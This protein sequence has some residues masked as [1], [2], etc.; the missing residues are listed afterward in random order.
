MELIN[1]EMSWLSFN[2]RVLQEAIDRNVPLIERIRFLGIYSNNM[3]EFFRVRVANI[4]RMVAI[5]KNTVQGY[6]GSAQDLLEEIRSIVIE[7]QKVFEKTY[8]SLVEELKEVSVFQVNEKTLSE[9]GRK[10]VQTFFHHDLKHV[11][12]PII[13]DPTREFP[14]LR[15][16]SIYLA[17]RLTVTTKKKPLF[18]L[19]EIPSN[20]PRFYQ[21]NENGSDYFLLIDD[22]I[23]LNLDSIFS[24]FQAEDLE[25]YTFKFTRDAELNLD[26]DLSVSFIEKI[27]KSLKNRKKG[28]PVRFVYDQRMPTD[29][30]NFLLKSLNLKS[31]SNAIP[32]GRYHNFK[33]FARFPDFGKK[34]L[35]YPQQTPVDN[36]LFYRTHSFIKRVLEQD[37]LLHFPYQRFDHV[38]DLLREA[39]ID[40]KVQSIKINVYRVASDSQIMNALMSA[41]S[42]GKEVVVMLELQARFDEENNLYWAERLKEHGAKVIYGIQG[43][44]V[45]SKLLQIIRVSKTKEQ[46]ISFIGTGNFNE[47]TARIYGDLGLLTADHEINSEVKKVFRLLENNIER[48]I[49]KHILVSPF[50]NRR[51]LNAFIQRE[52]ALAQTGKPASICIKVNN[53]VDS[54]LIAK[55][56][57]ASRAGVKIRMIVRGVCALIPNVK[58]MSENIEVI[59]IVDRYLEHARFFIFENDGNPTFIL[60]SADLMERN[61]DKRIEVGVPVYQPE[62]QEEIRTIFE[63]QW[64]DHVKARIVDKKQKNEYRSIKEKRA[65]RSQEKLHSYYEEKSKSIEIDKGA[66]I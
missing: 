9:E 2:E 59:S 36:P 43:L 38:V 37:V 54:K 55:L 27:E 28:E 58:K 10:K 50:N 7:Q 63:T 20:Y 30:K 19:V 33:D 14:K 62:L 41:V 23:R 34:E 60:T 16:K 46:A 12:V 65:I 21:F 25:A 35:I 32:G 6:K 11:I 24:I 39:A 8:Q 13:L 44:K 53:L 3:D 18:A 51:K 22:I 17:V 47:K 40:P 45:H 56:Y 29:L 5:K 4:K 26:D 42:N 31:G 61:L 52:I 57:E 66:V 48:G 1:R 15:D 49:Y 64:S